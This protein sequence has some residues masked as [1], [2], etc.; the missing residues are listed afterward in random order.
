MHDLRD[1]VKRSAA[2]Y[3]LVAVALALTGACQ[4]RSATA[5]TAATATTS[6]GD[7]PSL[8]VSALTTIAQ[9]A[10]LEQVGAGATATSNNYLGQSVTIPGASSYNNIRFNW[11]GAIA[12]A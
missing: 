12:T 1:R 4:S 3:F 8:P 11:D 10:T 9:S 5:P 6:P 7:S 2:T